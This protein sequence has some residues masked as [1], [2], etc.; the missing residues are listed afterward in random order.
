MI[1]R[2]FHEQRNHHHANDYPENNLHVPPPPNSLRRIRRA[3]QQRR[4]MKTLFD[5]LS[6][7]NDEYRSSQEADVRKGER[8]VDTVN[9]MRSAIAI[10]NAVKVVPKPSPSLSMSWWAPARWTPHTRTN[11]TTKTRHSTLAIIDRSMIAFKVMS[12]LY[13]ELHQPPFMVCVTARMPEK[14][15][16]RWAA[17]G[18]PTKRSWSRCLAA[19]GDGG[20]RCSLPSTLYCCRCVDSTFDE[21]LDFG[22]DSV[23]GRPAAF[24]RDLRRTCGR[25]SPSRRR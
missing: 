17:D 11:E 22:S 12:R 6:D 20:P 25:R 2:P 3:N 15:H 16:G 24:R 19:A 13:R 18:A 7:R 9:A 23:S 21:A 4:F 8:S 14:A 5:P 1:T 10:T